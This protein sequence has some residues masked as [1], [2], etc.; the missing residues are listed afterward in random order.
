[1]DGLTCSGIAKVPYIEDPFEV[2]EIKNLKID[3]GK[4]FTYFSGI[5][6]LMPTFAYY[7]HSMMDMYGQY[8]LLKKQYPEIN[9]I[10]FDEAK[11]GLAYNSSNG[12]K[13]TDDYM[14]L[15][16]KTKDDIL[17]ITI[18]SFIFEKVVFMFDVNLTF[19]KSFYENYGIK[20]DVSYLPFCS[21]Y[22]GTE[23]CGEGKYFKYNFIIIDELKKQFKDVFSANINKKIFI[24]RMRYNKYWMSIENKYSKIKK[25]NHS[26]SELLRMSKRRYYVHEE[27]IINIFK[28]NGYDI[29][30]PEDYGLFEQIQIFSSSSHIAGVEGT[31]AF[32]SFWCDP[33]TKYYEIK[34]NVHAS[35]TDVFAKYAGMDV[36]KINLIGMSLQE[37]IIEVK[38]ECF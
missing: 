23:K 19:P 35:H 29:I 28:E 27:N 4:S 8:L 12:K 9:I 14:S 24:S 15:F 2:Y 1:M 7:G 33:G 32:N 13:V 16:N 25:L 22:M 3:N 30:Y 26:Q 11:K 38:N 31:W 10:F 17:D 21:C 34:P 6:Y 37:A 18:N 20:D 5:T 36:K